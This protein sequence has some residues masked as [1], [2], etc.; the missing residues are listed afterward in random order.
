MG[1]I[2][3]LNENAWDKKVDDGAIWTIAISSEELEKVKNGDT[4]AL[5]IPKDWLPENIKAKKVLCLAS[6]GGQQGPIFATLGCDTTVLDF[7]EKQLEQ[8]ILVAKRDN[9][10]IK[11]VKGDMCDLSM[12]ESNSFDL[13]LCPVSVTY[14]SDTMPVFKECS[15]ILK[16]GGIFIFSAV[17]PHIYAFDGSTYDDGIFTVVNKLPFNSL[18]ELNE[19]ESK[20]FLV[21]KNA[22]EYSHTMQT[23]I[24]NQTECGFA[25][26]GF[27]ESNDEKDDICKYF[28]KFYTTK[29]IKI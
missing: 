21:S 15:R 6:G 25:I 10:K 8:D 22:I 26:V 28:S 2:I 23:L 20:E 19:E 12:F 17:N 13:I 5:G 16:Q 4:S 11:T 18:D 9:L 24:G 27:F 7:S 14:I 3:N 1:D 29:A